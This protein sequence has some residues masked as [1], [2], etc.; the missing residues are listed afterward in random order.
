MKQYLMNATLPASTFGVG[1]VN[2][3]IKLFLMILE[4]AMGWDSI[5]SI[6]TCWTVR[7][8]NPSGSKIFCISPDH[9]WDP[10]SP[11]YNRYQVIPGGKVAEAWLCRSERQITALPVLPPSV[12]S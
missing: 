3:R 4:M 6:A 10:P 5:L 1:T 9:P 11:P 8:L 7:G 12:P 2:C